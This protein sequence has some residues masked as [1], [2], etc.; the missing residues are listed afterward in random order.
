M[1]VIDIQDAVEGDDLPVCVG[2]RGAAPPEFCGGPTG[3]RLMIKRQR[4]GAAMS[5]P[6][7]LEAGIQMMAEAC[8]DWP[9]G[10]WDVLRSV[11]SDGFESIDRRLKEL[12]P[13]E[14]ERFS[15]QE[16]NARLNALVQSRR[17]KS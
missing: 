13:V 9:A 14:P 11:L 4:E 1:R 12:G 15:L 6:L 2:G 17:F 8:P 16:T 10:T 3:Y 5:D 7:R